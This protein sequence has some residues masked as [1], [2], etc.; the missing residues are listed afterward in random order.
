[1]IA[2]SFEQVHKSLLDNFLATF[3]MSDG[4]LKEPFTAVDESDG[5][6]SSVRVT[7]KLLLAQRVS[8]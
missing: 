1:M 3:G 5:P 2:I 6:D 8:A 4:L 7:K